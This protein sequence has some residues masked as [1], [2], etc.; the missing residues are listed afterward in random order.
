[1][2]TPLHAAALATALTSSIFALV[3]FAILEALKFR[4]YR[5]MLERVEDAV[6]FAQH[7]EAPQPDPDVEST[8]FD[9]VPE[10]ASS[11]A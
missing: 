11:A 1:M 8:F 7:G 6:E 10:V 5:R 4:L 3:G 2:L 9:G